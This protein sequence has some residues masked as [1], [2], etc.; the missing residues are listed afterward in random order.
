MT[1]RSSRDKALAIFTVGIACSVFFVDN[2]SLGMANIT[3][4]EI[5]KS[6][7]F[8]DGSLQWVLTAYSIM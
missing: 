5:K 6:L 4:P 3:L 8:N 7:D 2:A 1:A